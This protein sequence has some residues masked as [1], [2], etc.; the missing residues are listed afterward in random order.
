MTL[1][2]IFKKG[3]QYYGDISIGYKFI[4]NFFWNISVATSLK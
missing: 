3:Y 1:F 4:R 2:K